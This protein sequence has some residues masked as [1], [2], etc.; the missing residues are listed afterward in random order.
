MPC[1]ELSY[2]PSL[3]VYSVQQHN[4]SYIQ[5]IKLNLLGESCYPACYHHE[6]DYFIEQQYAQD[7]NYLFLFNL[8]YICIYL[9]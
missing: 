5:L 7:C 9:H 8:Y 3:N 2:M 1:L 6:V 4:C